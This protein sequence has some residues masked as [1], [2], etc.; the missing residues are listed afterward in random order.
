MLVKVFIDQPYHK[1][2][3]SS[4]HSMHTEKEALSVIVVDRNKA[5]TSRASDSRYK[6]IIDLRSI[7]ILF[8]KGLFRFV[9]DPTWS[10]ESSTDI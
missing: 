7:H 10:Y 8:L 6:A 3:F 5:Q 4:L 2:S 9:L 1:K